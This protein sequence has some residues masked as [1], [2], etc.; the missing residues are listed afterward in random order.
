MKLNLEEI[1]LINIFE[2]ITRAT[3]KD[4]FELNQLV[5]IVDESEVGKVIGKKG[6]NLKRMESLL[7]KKIKIVGFNKDP[8]KFLKNYVNPLILKSVNLEKDILKISA[9]RKTKGLL[10][11]RNHKNLEVLKELF[12]RHFKLEIMLK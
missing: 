11:G 3:V 8:I 6:S 10:I 2:R 4:F 5:F 1:Q 12:K 7:K 9:D